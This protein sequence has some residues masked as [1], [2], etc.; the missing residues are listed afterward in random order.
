MPQQKDP[1]Y[2]AT[3]VVTGATKVVKDTA[4][5]AYDAMQDMRAKGT[6]L[7]EDSKRESGRR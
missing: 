6:K 5:A 3:S 7:W 4:K 1:T 2:D